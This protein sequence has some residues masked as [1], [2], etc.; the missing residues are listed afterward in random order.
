[1]KWT[2]LVP[3]A[4]PSQPHLLVADGDDAAPVCV[5]F[6]EALRQR[7]EHDAALDEVVK[8]HGPLVVAIKQSRA[9]VAEVHGAGRGGG[10]DRGIISK[11]GEWIWAWH[12]YGVSGDG[13]D[14]VMGLV[15]VKEN[16][17]SVAKGL[18]CL[19]EFASV[20]VSRSVSVKPEEI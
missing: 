8:L 7:L 5:G 14:L 18:Q 3:L 20:Y 1:M 12:V 16:L 4:L 9:Q 13:C 6:S 2:G 10:V 11:L 19:L 17:Q 15:M